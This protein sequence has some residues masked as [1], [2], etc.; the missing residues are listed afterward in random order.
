MMLKHKD[1]AHF[2]RDRFDRI[3]RPGVIVSYPNRR[4]A[5]MWVIDAIVERVE[6]QIVLRG[7]P[8]R[9]LVVTPIQEGHSAGSARPWPIAHGRTVTV[10]RLDRVTVIPDVGAHRVGR[11]YT[12]FNL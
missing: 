8:A 12:L 11:K 10:S 3:I 9:V 5:H 2:L 4:G 7:W 1:D 6:E